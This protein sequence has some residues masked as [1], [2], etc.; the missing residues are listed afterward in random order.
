MSATKS[1][2][3]VNT[4]V[5]GLN[6]CVITMLRDMPCVLVI[7]PTA[8]RDTEAAEGLPFGPFEPQRHRTL[9]I[10]LRNLVEQQTNVSLGYVEQLYT[11]GDRGRHDLVPG[12]NARVVSV[13]YLALTRLSDG[14]DRTGR[15]RAS[16]TSSRGKTGGTK[17]PPSSTS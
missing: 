10:G 12:E 3:G 14:A 2:E 15:W 8:Q 5:I 6:A 11:F 7:K 4:V 17:S 1:R 13:G 16:T 9:E